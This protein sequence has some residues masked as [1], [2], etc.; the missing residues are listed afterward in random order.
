MILEHKQNVYLLIAH[1][2]PQGNLTRYEMDYEASGW[3]QFPHAFIHNNCT[4]N[5]TNRRIQNAGHQESWQTWQ[6]VTCER[7]ILG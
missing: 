1:N 5:V 2:T 4:N 6:V 7:S 3:T